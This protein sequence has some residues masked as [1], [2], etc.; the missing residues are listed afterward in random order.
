[1][2]K[3]DFINKISLAP[4]KA[5]LAKTE[6]V[7]QLPMDKAI[8]EI[9]GKEND[10]PESK[11]KSSSVKPKRKREKNIQQEANTDVK[12]KHVQIRMPDPV[13]RQAKMMVLQ[14]GYGGICEMLSE[15]VSKEMEK[16]GYLPS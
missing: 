1:M 10:I 7:S 3:K 6:E 9:H 4:K 5:V 16:R 11:A 8:A 14:E 13:W 15:I 2:G 12:M